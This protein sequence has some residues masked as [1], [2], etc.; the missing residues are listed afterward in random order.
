MSETVDTT[1]QASDQAGANWADLAEQRV[2]DEALRLAPKA[3]WNTGLVS[4]ALVAA[5]LSDA[6]GQLLLP[7]GPRDLAALLS[8]RHDAV[9]LARLQAFDVATLKIRQRI[10]EGVVA[11]LDSAQENADALGP[12]A[13]FLAFPT[14]LALALRLTWES[15]D[16]IWRW[17]GDTATDEN[18]YSKR[19][20]LSGILISTLAVDF[21]SGR[22]SA[23]SHLDARI[24]NVMAFEKWKAGLKPMD[25]ASEMVS[26]LARMRFGK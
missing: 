17:A 23:L 13:A 11:R 24:D 9:A 20:I 19:A 6:E 3:G 25:L 5:G 14:N 8:R 18:H 21:A 10:R 1:G 15:A 22:V 4:R 12:L 2:L 7:E 26:A 16:V